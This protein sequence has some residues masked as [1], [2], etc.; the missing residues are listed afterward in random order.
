MTWGENFS[1]TDYPTREAISNLSLKIT[2]LGN[3]LW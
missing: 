2:T 3:R 1:I